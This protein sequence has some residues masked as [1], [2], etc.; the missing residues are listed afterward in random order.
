MGHTDVTALLTTL[1][2]SYATG[3]PSPWENHLTPDVLCIGTDE[4]EWWQG[5]DAFLSAARAQL[6]EMI[7]AGIRVTPGDPT[8]TDR[9][10]HVLVADRPTLHLPDGTTIG[11]RL[12]LA[13]SRVDETL[14]IE[15]MHMSVP[16]S[17][18]DVLRQTLTV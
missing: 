5:R 16:A 12:T 7:A 15:Q 14:T 6:A 8:I 2:D 1:Y 17:N 3:D 13:L 9:D 18:E 4:A 11:V 10:S